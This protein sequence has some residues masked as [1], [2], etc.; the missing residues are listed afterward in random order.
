[1][2]III[3]MAGSGT[4]FQSMGI[5]KPKYKIVANGKS[6]F[7][8]SMLS[9][10]SFF[11]Y[12]FIFISRRDIYDYAF[13]KK[14]CNSIGINHYQFVV[15]DAPTKG[16][17]DT[18]LKAEKY[19]EGNDSCII[20]NIDTYIKEFEILETDIP[21]FADGFIPVIRA[22]GDR[23]S[24]IKVNDLGVLTDIVEKKPISDLASIGFYYFRKW[25]D[26]KEAFF[27]EKDKI[28]EEYKEIYIA[29]LY[30]K[31]I[32]SGKELRT[33]I[34]DDN[35]VFILGTHEEIIGFDKEYLKNNLN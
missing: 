26:F 35:N 29:P 31:L 19:M 33:K 10:K 18:A 14:I 32:N 9:L 12:E 21:P 8:W 22:V 13:I 23:W 24:F 28:L 34:L 6:L 16:Q 11:R 5:K 1:M 20:Y 2:K 27:E 17:A 7:E 3:T 15:L 4:R 30:K 25:L